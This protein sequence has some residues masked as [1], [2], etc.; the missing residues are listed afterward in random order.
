MSRIAAARSRRLLLSLVAIS[1]LS[2]TCTARLHRPRLGELYER[3]AQAHGPDRNPIIVIPGLLGSRLKDSESGRMVWGAFGGGYASPREPDGRRLIALPM[4]EGVPLRDLRDSVHTDGVL[5]R[6]KIRVWGMPVEL[7][8]YFFILAAL[9]TGGYRDETLG[10]A[11]AIDY[12]EDHFTCFQFEYDWRRD[13]VEN[14]ARLHDFILEKRAYVQEEIRRRW[15]VEDA[16]VK[17]DLVAHSM[18]GLLTRYFLQYGAADLPEDGS[19]PPLTWE[20]AAYVDRAILVGPPNAGSVEAF[21]QLLEGKD[22][23]PFIPRY[24]AALIGTYPSA[25]QLLPRSRHGL[26]VRGEDPTQPVGDLLDADLWERMG[27]GLASPDQTGV[28]ESLLP[29]VSRPAERQRIALDHLRK[30]LARARQ[31]ATAL[32]RSAVP[33]QGLE[34]I[35]LAGDARPTPAMLAVDARTGRTRVIAWEPGDGTVLRSSAL[36]DERRGG[37]WTPML[38]SPIAWDEVRFLFSGHFKMTK[39]PA[40]LDNVLYLLLEDPR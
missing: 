40:F 8:A 17:F 20:G 11:R 4:A 39:D 16:D 10:L 15:G 28:L 25:Y 23:G 21:I 35:L 7:R 6:I 14:A 9:G 22:F 18:G 1:V 36:L 30:S 19:L 34:L 27:W 29:G 24:P 2:A 12:G 31:F 33:P 32:D 13:N 38:V 37:T 3:A 26:I 5:D